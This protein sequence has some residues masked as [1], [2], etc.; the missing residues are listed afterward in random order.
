VKKYSAAMVR[1]IGKIN[2]NKKA[3]PFTSRAIPSPF[4]EG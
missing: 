2:V 3:L 4:G 1:N